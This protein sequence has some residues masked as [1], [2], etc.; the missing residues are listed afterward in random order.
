MFALDCVSF[1]H[2]VGGIA[3]R[4]A[5]FLFCFEQPQIEQN[6]WMGKEGAPSDCSPG[7]AGPQVETCCSKD[8]CNHNSWAVSPIS[9]WE[10]VNIYFAEMFRKRGG[11]TL[12]IHDFFGGNNLSVNPQSSFSNGVKVGN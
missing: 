11:S 5:V 6:T 3:E 1:C 10:I 4:K 8:S 12:R 9:V 2:K 7:F